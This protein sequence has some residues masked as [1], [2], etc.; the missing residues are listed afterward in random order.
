M[1]LIQS[2]LGFFKREDIKFNELIGSFHDMQDTVNK[3]SKESQEE[4][5]KWIKKERT[6]MQKEEEYHN[7]VLDLQSEL[8]K[9]ESDHY[10]IVVELERKVAHLERTVLKLQ[11]ATK[12][13]A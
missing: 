3:I 6:W 11:N 2:F 1:A 13:A 12:P 5:D 7:K 9:K 8:M 4:R 10:R